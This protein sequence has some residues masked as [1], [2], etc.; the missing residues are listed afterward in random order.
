ME[1]NELR[2]IFYRDNP[3]AN[4]NYIKSGVAYYYVLLDKE[5]FHFAIPIDDM[6]EGE[7]RDQMEAKHL[8]RWLIEK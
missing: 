8:V 4:F 6:G 7:F 3:M 2:K 5:T 1:R